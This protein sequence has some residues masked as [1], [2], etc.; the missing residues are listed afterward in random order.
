MV[1]VPAGATFAL[2]VKQ[3]V[4]SVGVVVGVFVGMV[5]VVLV[6]MGAEVP[7]GATIAL[8]VVPHM[9]LNVRLHLKHREFNSCVSFRFWVINHCQMVRFRR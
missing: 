5:E 1:E 8:F 7:V 2:V 6:V 9:P 4:V 3:R